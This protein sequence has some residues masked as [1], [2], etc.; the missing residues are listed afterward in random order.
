MIRRAPSSG[1]DEGAKRQY[2]R[3]VWN[4]LAKRI[5]P[6]CADAHVLLMPSAEGDEV[7]VAQGKGFRISNMHL[8]DNSPALVAHYLAKRFPSAHRYGTAVWR[9][10][11]RAARQGI[12]FSAL[13]LDMTANLSNALAAELY[14]I[15]CQWKAFARSAFIAVTVQKGRETGEWWKGPGGL[16]NWEAP[17]ALKEQFPRMDGMTLSR[18]ADIRWLLSAPGVAE[19]RLA[20]VEQYR[21]ARVPMIYAVFERLPWT[22][23]V[24]LGSGAG[25][26]EVRAVDDPRNDA[27]KEAANIV[28]RAALDS[29]FRIRLGSDGFLEPQIKSRDGWENLRDVC[30]LLHSTDAKSV[31]V[32]QL[33]DVYKLPETA[34]AM[35]MAKLIKADRSEAFLRSQILSRNPE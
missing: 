21:T 8:V 20:F 27:W 9:A 13:N 4:Q 6:H 23:V 31:M 3:T 17:V 2:R 25:M 16:N 28:I 30:A 14:L 7:E 24:D 19:Y 32:G 18:M 12:Q 5:A 29:G 26:A 10:V 15:A 11:Y 22:T 34:Q 1:Y 33:H 35:F